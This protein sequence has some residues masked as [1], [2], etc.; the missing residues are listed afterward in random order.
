MRRA[1]VVVAVLGA[2]ILGAVMVA[3]ASRPKVTDPVT[4]SVVERAVSDVVIDIGETGDSSGDL[5]TFANPLYDAGNTE[6]VGR[7]QGDCV[8][9]SPEKGTWECRWTSW[10]EDGSITIEGSFSDTKATTVAITGGT[11][12][13]ANA[14]GS[15]RLEVGEDEGTYLFTYHVQP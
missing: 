1:S 15:M 12:M 9:I 8:R 4:I 14:R 7:D 13:Y 11:G 5:L 3:T 10:L 2:F 6:K